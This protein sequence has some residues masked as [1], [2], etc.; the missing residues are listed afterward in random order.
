MSKGELLMQKK[1]IPDIPDRRALGYPKVPFS[2]YCKLCWEPV[3]ILWVDKKHAPEG[4]AFGHET[5]ESC[6]E[7][8]W[9]GSLRKT[10]R[11]LNL[12]AKQIGE[13]SRE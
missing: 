10:L 2:A 4:C 3:Y 6:E 13:Q 1:V 8:K 7:P 9:R 12:E 5:A 11:E